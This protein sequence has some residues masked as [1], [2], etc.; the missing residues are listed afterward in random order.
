MKKIEGLTPCG[1]AYAII[2]YYDKNNKEVDENLATKCII[3]EFDANN[4]L[5]K[6]TVSIIQTSLVD[7]NMS[8]TDVSLNDKTNEDLED[9]KEIPAIRM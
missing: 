6:E 7:D 1:G 3:C 2:Y 5:L 8:Q 4:K 9:T